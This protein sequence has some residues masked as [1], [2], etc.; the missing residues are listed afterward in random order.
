[1]NLKK[2]NRKKH[3][4]ISKLKGGGCMSPVPDSLTEVRIQ[5]KTGMIIQL[6]SL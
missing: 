3:D 4:I 5:R 2:K 6:L 1:M